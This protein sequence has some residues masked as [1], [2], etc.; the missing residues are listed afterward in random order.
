MGGRADL[1]DL[2]RPDQAATADTDGSGN[3]R[4]YIIFSTYMSA[5]AA[6]T[7]EIWLILAAEIDDCAT[8]DSATDG[9]HHGAGECQSRAVSLQASC[10]NSERSLASAHALVF[11]PLRAAAV[12]E[13]D[14]PAVLLALCR[15]LVCPRGP[16][17]PVGLRGASLAHSSSEA[18]A[19]PRS[20][21]PAAAAR[22]QLVRPRCSADERGRNL[23]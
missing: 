23:N 16:V 10:T 5:G 17:L 6:R 3:E 11:Y 13:S 19:K 18:R 22:C 21:P 14:P 9:G 2:T 7:G 1:A 8:D 4:T 15:S 20:T 12:S